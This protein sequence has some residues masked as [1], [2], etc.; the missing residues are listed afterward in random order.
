MR[1][2]VHVT[3]VRRRQSSCLFQLNNI[4]IAKQ[5]ISLNRPIIIM[6]TANNFKNNLVNFDNCGEGIRYNIP[7]TVC[8]VPFGPM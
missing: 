7:E 4:N 1:S 8:K 3:D 2:C 5:I 6:I